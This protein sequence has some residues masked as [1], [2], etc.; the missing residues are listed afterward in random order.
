MLGLQ[1]Q[2]SQLQLTRRVRSNPAEEETEP[3]PSDSW[4]ER[5]KK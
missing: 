2:G 4:K 3:E 5:I 1:Q